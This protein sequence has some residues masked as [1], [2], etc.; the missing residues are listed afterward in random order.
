MKS[1]RLIIIILVI[2]C[3]GLGVFAAVSFSGLQKANSDR[4]AT[5]NTLNTLGEE[6]DRIAKE[7]DEQKKTKLDLE[8]Q[9][10]D[11]KGKVSALQD[12]AEKLAA[13]LAEEKK[14][15]EDALSELNDKNKEIDD[16]KTNWESEKISRTSLQE[17]YDKLQKEYNSIQEQLR[18]VTSTNE[19]LKK[20]VEE[21]Q[22]GK[23]VE[24]DKIVVKPGMEA[25]GKVLVVNKEFNFIVVAAGNNKGIT[26]G[27]IFG[28]FRDGK[29]IA[30]AQVE[31]VYETMSA[32]NI[33]EG[34]D[35]REGDIAKAM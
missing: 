5:Q 26:P 12:K 31:K 18:T 1:F 8:A 3:V 29:L 30:K 7:L 4:V 32:A 27:V 33:T 35:I 16:I 10:A 22:A 15:K 6:K 21:L 13:M 11:L 14:A 17:Q 34:A 25:E 2:L 20:Q 24:L 9:L 28:V 19:N 23:E